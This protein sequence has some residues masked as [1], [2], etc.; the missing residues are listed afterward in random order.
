MQLGEMT[1]G[2]Y[3]LLWFYSIIGMVWLIK[4]FILATVW[5]MDKLEKKFRA[6]EERLSKEKTE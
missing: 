5:I 6:E 1:F 4:Q 2:L 3:G